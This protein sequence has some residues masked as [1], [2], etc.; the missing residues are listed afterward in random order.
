MGVRFP[1]GAQRAA[2]GAREGIEAVASVVKVGDEGLEPP[3]FS[4]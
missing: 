2:R 4:V 3:T 1:P